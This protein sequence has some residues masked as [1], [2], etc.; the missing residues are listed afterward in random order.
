VHSPF[1]GDSLFV[2]STGIQALSDPVTGVAKLGMLAADCAARAIAR[3]V[4]EA[5]SFGGF[6]SYK[7]LFEK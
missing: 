3:G 6:E 4:Y 1:D 5:E 7:S 2:L